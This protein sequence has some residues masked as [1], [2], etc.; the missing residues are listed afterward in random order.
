MICP[1]CHTENRA[2]AKFCDECGFRLPQPDAPDA[3][4]ASDK[5]SQQPEIDSATVD[6]VSA[7]QENGIPFDPADADELG[8]SRTDS[9]AAQP[10]SAGGEGGSDVVADLLPA[11]EP[12]SFDALADSGS[13]VASATD[14]AADSPADAP[15]ADTAFDADMA[16]ADDSAQDDGASD[17]ADPFTTSDKP[18]SESPCIDFGS[19]SLAEKRA[20]SALSGWDKLEAGDDI[21]LHAQKTGEIPPAS[22]AFGSDSIRRA[23]NSAALKGEM[24]ALGVPSR[25][26]AIA[27]PEDTGSQK[28][29]SAAKPAEGEAAADLSGFDEY[30][31]DSSY[32]P[33]ESAYRRGDTMKL[34]PISATP[35]ERTAFVAPDPTKKS[36]RRP[37]PTSSDAPV[38]KGDETKAQSAPAPA[39]GN[40]AGKK[41]AR[42][43]SRGTRIALIAVAVVAVVCAIC[44]GVTY[45]MELWGGKVVPD[46]ATMTQSDAAF[47]L[48]NKGFEVRTT[49]VPSDETEGIVLLMD[50]KA[51]SRLE[52]GSE[53]VIHVS[54]ARTIPEIVGK[55][56]D[57]AKKLLE[58]SGFSNINVSTEKSDEAEGS[59]LSVEPAAGSKAKAASAISVVV[60]EPYTVPDVDG[61]T[62]EEAAGAIE[63]AG[64]SPYRVVVYNESVAEGSLLGVDPASGTKVESGSVV[65]ISVSKSR[66][67][68]LV[69]AARS[70]LSGASLAASD[71]STFA[72]ASVD[73][74]TYLGSDKVSFTATGRAS[75]SVSVL[76]QTLSVS[77]DSKQVTGLLTFD[78]NNNVTTVSFQ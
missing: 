21:D 14:A 48:Q 32:V 27:S 69:A 31:V 53:V 6:E 54:T 8:R 68:E 23:S 55:S 36:R 58:D 30:L 73:S 10:V 26:C 44:A 70:Y 65:T 35:A 19:L 46:V 52:E 64:L 51:G 72:V 62:V 25:S 22:L 60:A 47:V 20:Q 16:G 57:E 1:Q 66:G 74:C 76:G 40:D 37:K 63:E 33:P 28:S 41:A 18:S 71:G 15:D 11:T 49:S 43:R 42:N 34:P 17:P 4:A 12:G 61:M 7:N 45:Q 56:A 5:P 24:S 29:V 9:E 38:Q 2:A 77:G 75:T 67:S 13:S 39:D 78:A 59:V 50:P 3:P